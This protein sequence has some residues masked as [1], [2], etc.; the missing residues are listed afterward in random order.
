MISYELL[1]ITTCRNVCEV[2]SDW[3]QPSPFLPYSDILCKEIPFAIEAVRY[4][5]HF[6]GTQVHK[7]ICSSCKT[8]NLY[9][10][11]FQKSLLIRAGKYMLIW[12]GPV[13]LPD[14]PVCSVLLPRT[15][16]FMP[17]RASD[18]LLCGAHNH[19]PF[20]HFDK[21]YSAITPSRTL[22]TMFKFYVKSWSA[23]INCSKLLI[24][25]NSYFIKSLII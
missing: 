11:E 3:T 21:L 14:S 17:S 12:L 1:G 6:R 4:R 16:L 5:M 2:I 13:L 18:R 20:K 7:Y 22:N 25:I 15:I 9:E 23:P 24:F 10:S 8:F 19:S